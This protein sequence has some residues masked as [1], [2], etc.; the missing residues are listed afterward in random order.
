MT[1]GPSAKA[2][3]AERQAIIKGDQQSKLRPG[4]HEPSTMHAMSRL[5]NDLQGRQSA[6]DYLSGS[7]A[8]THYPAIPSGPWSSS[9]GRLPDELPLG[10]AIDAQE[11]CG[12]PF[13]VAASIAALSAAASAPV[14]NVVAGTAGGAPSAS[15]PDVAA[16]P[17]SS[18]NG[19]SA[20]A[21]QDAEEGTRPSPSTHIVR[22]SVSSP[23]LR[24][25]ARKL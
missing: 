17:A 11:A 5:S 24:R 20:S 8:A 21:S 18:S 12:E 10:V 2:E 6:R 7:E 9:Y 19:A 13:E 23:T 16:P 25:L 22:G 15:S 4:E 1:N 14:A 3:Q